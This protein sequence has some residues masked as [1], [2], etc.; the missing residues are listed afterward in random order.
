MDGIRPD[1]VEYYLVWARE[2]GIIYDY[3][4]EGN[5]FDSSYVKI[6]FHRY[7]GAVPECHKFNLESIDALTKIAYI[8]SVDSSLAKKKLNEKYGLGSMVMCKTVKEVIFNKPATII[9]WCDGTKTIVKCQKGDKFNKETGVALCFLKKLCGNSSRN[10]NDILKL[11][12]EGT[13]HGSNTAH[14]KR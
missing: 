5:Y 2:R 11:A 14:K 10:L 7:E 1:Q 9:R 3:T 12:E 13:D 6:C 8:L 4:I